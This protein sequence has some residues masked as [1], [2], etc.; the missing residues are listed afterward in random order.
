MV[1][2]LLIYGFNSYAKHYIHGRAVIP[3]CAAYRMPRS[4]PMVRSLSH[5][6]QLWHGLHSSRT[7]KLNIEWF[8][9]VLIYCDIYRM[10]QRIGYMAKSLYTAKFICCDNGLGIWWSPYMPWHFY[11]AKLMVTS[12]GYVTWHSPV[13]SHCNVLWVGA[14]AWSW[15]QRFEDLE[16]HGNI[17]LG[18]WLGGMAWFSLAYG[19]NDK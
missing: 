3:W 15:L 10:W 12:N 4:Y 11:A 14:C 1:E 6:A 7:V 13:A 5:A 16:P 2:G 17:T 18:P 9:E 8:G 19:C